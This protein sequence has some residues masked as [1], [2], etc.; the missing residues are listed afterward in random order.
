LA[1]GAKN[2][3]AHGF[4]RKQVA[5]K[6][7]IPTRAGEILNPQRW[8]QLPQTIERD[9]WDLYRNTGVAHL[10]SISGLHITMFAWLAGIGVGAL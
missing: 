10:V 1:S 8:T 5:A 6:N 3:I 4:V 7:S 9:D 2:S